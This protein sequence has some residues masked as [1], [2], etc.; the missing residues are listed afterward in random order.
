[1]PQ[2]PESAALG[3]QDQA[4]PVLKPVVASCSTGV[5]SWQAIESQFEA[6]EYAIERVASDP[7][8]D[9]CLSEGFSSVGDTAWMSGHWYGGRAHAGEGFVINIIN[10]NGNGNRA[11]VMWFTYRP[12]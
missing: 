12:Q 9:R 4:A 10:G 11:V 8:G 6:G 3:I 5:V 7:Y 2:R 1:L